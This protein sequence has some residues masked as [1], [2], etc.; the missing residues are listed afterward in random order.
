MDQLE[1]L[2]QRC[3]LHPA[4]LDL[5]TLSQV[6]LGQMRIGLYGGASS[7]PMRP[8]ALDPAGAVRETGE[9][10]LTLCTEAELC[11]ARYRASCGELDY[12]E[13]FPLPGLDYPAPLADLLFGALALAEPYLETADAYTLVLPYALSYSETGEVFLAKQPEPLRLSD[14]EGVDLIEA[15]RVQ[16]A[17]LGYPQ[18][19]VRVLASMTA[20]HRAAVRSLPGQSR[21]L[22]LYWGERFDLGLVLPKSAV[23]KQKSG[24]NRLQLLACGAGEFTGFPFGAL[25][26]IMDRDAARPGEAL[27]DKSLA[28]RHLGEQVRYALIKGVETAGLFSFMCGR[29]FLSLRSLSIETALSFLEQAEGEN[30]LAEFCRHEPGDAAAAL[31]IVQAVI[32]RALR[33]ISSQLAAGLLLVGAGASE[34]APACVALSGEGF[35]QPYLRNRFLKTQLPLLREH[36]GLHVRVYYE[37]TAPYLG[38]VF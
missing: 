29:D 21:Y 4:L 28:L 32:D 12:G 5:Q 36:L 22:S 34:E 1:K 2:L 6:A 30:R 25:D 9:V 15:L 18:C 11:T 16:L 14:W 31:C 33:L 35:A 27:L 26:L 37:E 8:T 7:M 17:E 3:A 20:A 38:G 24:E 13:R 23:L 10:V 19:T